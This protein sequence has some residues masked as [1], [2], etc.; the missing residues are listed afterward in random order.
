MSAAWPTVSLGEL[1]RLERRPVDVVA[2]HQYQEIGTYSYGRGIFH[3]TPRSG[4]EVGNKDL[5]MMKKGDLI[6]QITFAWEGAI[7]L[8]SEAEDGLFGSVRYPTFRV[9]EERCFAP[10]L[11][12]YL[13]TRKGLEQIGRI[14]PGSAGRNRVLAL[15]RLP[16][17]MVPLPPR[18]EQCRIIARVE[19]LASSIG[20]AKQLRFESTSQSANLL[21]ASCENML[22]RARSS[23]PIRKLSSL[24]NP[25]RGISYGIVQ[26]GA[27]YEGGVPTLRAGDLQW[28]RVNT[29]RVKRVDPKIE[30]GYTR[31]RLRGNELLLRIRGGVGELAVCPESMAGGNVSREIAVIPLASE[32]LPRFAMFLLSARS[33]QTKMHGNVRGTSYLGINLKDVRELEIPVPTLS[34][35]ETML[36]ELER[37]KDKVD[38]LTTYQTEVAAE[39]D[40]MLPAILD[41]AF[42]G[43]LV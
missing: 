27:E 28:F 34:L 18:A 35:Q 38:A 7:A 21:S 9:D 15:K 26:T 17:V 29:D 23:G 40:A 19:S 31:T 4:L 41:K 22:N 16:E 5:F 36:S 43:E 33:S 3:K 37:L 30:R 32:V 1:I 8:C 20:Q 13:T 14:C 10:F 24:V 39:L 2:D 6:L 12:K 25:D 42:K 11:V